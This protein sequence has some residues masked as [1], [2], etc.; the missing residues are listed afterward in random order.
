MENKLETF[1]LYKRY[2]TILLDMQLTW[3]NRLEKLLLTLFIMVSFHFSY[4]QPPNDDCISAQFLCM[5][6][7]T[8]GTTAAASPGNNICFIPHATVWYSFTTN[9][10]GGNVNVIVNRDSTCN[11]PGSTGDGLQGVVFISDTPCDIATM[12]P[13]SN[14]LSGEYGFVLSAPSLL[15]ETQYWIQIDG[16]VNDQG[17]TTSCDFT[18]NVTG[19]GVSVSAGPDLT[20]VAGQ[21]INLEG[22]GA[23]TYSWNPTNTLDNPASQTPLANPTET[24]TYTLTGSRDGC[25]SSDNMTVFIIDP[26][27]APNAF[28]PNGD[29]YNDT[30]DIEGIYRFPNAIVEVYSRWGQRIFSSVGY[31]TEWNGTNNGTYI[32]E[33]TYYWVIQL[34]DPGIDNEEPITGYVAIIR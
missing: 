9:E 4:A 11:T 2:S 20:I 30:W 15:P 21:S 32:P 1:P 6:D 17:D 26:I 28:T 19:P 10:L 23:V 7:P 24:T 27:K 25:T 3:Q 31:I 14:C 16:I 33:G 34:N 29:G 8:L 5:D 12:T 13:V 18:V 22:A